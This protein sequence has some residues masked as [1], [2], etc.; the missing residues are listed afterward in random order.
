MGIGSSGSRLWYEMCE[1]DV[2]ARH[3]HMA[4]YGL[5][6]KQRR[7]GLLDCLSHSVDRPLQLS[8]DAGE[9]AGSGEVDTASLLGTILDPYLKIFRIVMLGSLVWDECRTALKRNWLLE[10]SLT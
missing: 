2:W 1:H 8:V 5:Q 6:C 4:T 3:W 10:C 7:R 9:A